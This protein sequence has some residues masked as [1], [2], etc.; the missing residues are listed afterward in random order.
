M[1]NEQ[2]QAG[3]RQQALGPLPSK[4]QP[5]PMGPGSE[6]SMLSQLIAHSRDTLLLDGA[7]RKSKARYNK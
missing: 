2:K 1:S 6:L 4:N 5:R 7:H 3:V